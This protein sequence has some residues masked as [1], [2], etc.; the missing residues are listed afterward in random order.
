MSN[1]KVDFVQ[2][3]Y[4]LL[5]FY[6]IVKKKLTLVKKFFQL[7]WIFFLFFLALEAFDGLYRLRRKDMLHVTRIFFRNGRL[8]PQR[9]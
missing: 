9:F 4:I 7:F 6:A 5:L 8:H 2:P 3:F 1:K